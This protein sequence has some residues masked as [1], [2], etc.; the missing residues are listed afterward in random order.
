M[1]KNPFSSPFKLPGIL[2]FLCLLLSLLACRAEQSA[3]QMFPD[4]A[5]W[6]VIGDSITHGGSYYAWVYLYY[7]TRFPDQELHVANCGVSGDTTWGTNKRYDWDIVPTSPTTATIMLGMN[8]VGRNLY[9][10]DETPELASQRA[11]RIASYQSNLRKLVQKLQA[12]GVT[13]TLI[14]PSPYDE[15]AEIDRAS[16][17]G[18]NA[19]LGEMGDFAQ[20]LADEEGLAVVEFHDPMTE[21]NHQL[22]ADDPSFTLIGPDRIH[23]QWP[24][25]FVMAYLLLTAQQAPAVVSSVV[26]DS[27]TLKV[28]ADRATVSGLTRSAGGLSFTCREQAL[29]FPIDKGVEPALDYVPFTEDL[30]QEMLTVTGLS[31]DAY[32]LRIDDVPIGTFSGAE[33]AAG[34]NLATFTDT[35]QYRQA[36][37]V[38]A[39]VNQWR[40]E[41]YKLRTLA[42]IEHTKVGDVSHPVDLEQVRPQLEAQL[43]KYETTDAGQPHAAYYARS[44]KNYLKLKPQEAAIRQKVQDLEAQIPQAAQPEPHRYTLLPVSA[45]GT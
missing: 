7:A 29:P 31:G 17:T 38:L 15:T 43:K 4:G 1:H 37:S 34:V 22:Q 35:P 42:F 40:Q 27:S 9:G 8:D 32:A 36:L 39:L 10:Q 5:R 20:Q 25:H 45:P 6:S 33:W 23:P 41:V 19:A 12:D 11:K 30:N 13:V 2:A 28:E 18:V 14:T 24:G 44:L 21:L 3:P 16:A 26:I